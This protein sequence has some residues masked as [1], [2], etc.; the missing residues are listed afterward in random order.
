MNIY[1]AQYNTYYI[2]ISQRL[3]AKFNQIN[4]STSIL[5]VTVELKPS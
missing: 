4:Q 3:L 1:N 2:I 5:Q